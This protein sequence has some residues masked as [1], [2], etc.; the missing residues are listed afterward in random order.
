MVTPDGVPI[1]P[2]W[3]SRYFLGADSNGR[4]IVV[5]LLYG[6]RNSLLI[7]VWAALITD[8]PR[9]PARASLA[10]FFGVAPWTR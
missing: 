2:T 9:G 3:Q 4:D 8:V 10:G 7:G 6:G 1:G 5:R